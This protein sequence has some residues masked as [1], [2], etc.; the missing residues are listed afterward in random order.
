MTEITHAETHQTTSPARSGLVTGTRWALVALAALFT[1]GAMG[2]FFLVGLSM[3]EDG[4][5]WQDHKTLGHVVGLLPYV[6]WIPAL[7]GKTSR[8]LLI[9]TLALFILFW[10]QYAFINVDNGIAKAM[11]PLNGTFLLLLGA[12]IFRTSLAQARQGR[13]S[14]KESA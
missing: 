11:H 12:W 9:G 6:M 10:A 1:I 8:G 7:L 2:Q 14:R 5:H 4:A 3:F 13:H